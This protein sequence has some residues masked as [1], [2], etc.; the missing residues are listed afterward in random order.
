MHREI[1]GKPK[2]IKVFLTT[3]IKQTVLLLLYKNRLV[4]EECCPKKKECCPKK[5][6]EVKQYK[7]SGV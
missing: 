4:S 1:C 6:E 3:A 7:F 5:K 2:P